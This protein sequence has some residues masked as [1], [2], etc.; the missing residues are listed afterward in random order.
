MHLHNKRC[1]LAVVYEDIP[2][3]VHYTSHVLCNIPYIFQYLR[4]ISSLA[5]YCYIIIHCLEVSCKE[6]QIMSA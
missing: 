3:L 4:N 6:D 1:D 2:V 5:V